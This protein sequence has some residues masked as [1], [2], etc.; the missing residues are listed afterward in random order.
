[1]TLA[2]RIVVLSPLKGEAATNLECSSAPLELY[3]NPDNK[4]VA[5]FIGSPR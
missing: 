2:N 5:G 4:F 3:H 1:M